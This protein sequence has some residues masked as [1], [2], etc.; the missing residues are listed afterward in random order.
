MKD[1]AKS[2][3]KTIQRPKPKLVRSKKGGLLPVAMIMKMIPAW[4]GHKST[5]NSSFRT[6][7]SP[8]RARVV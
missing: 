4:I 6:L 1:A 5:R 2:F 7:D 3:R 8:P